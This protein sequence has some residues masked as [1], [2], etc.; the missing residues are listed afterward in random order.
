M[1]VFFYLLIAFG[2]LIGIL[3][4]LSWNENAAEIVICVLLVIFWPILI[5]IKISEKK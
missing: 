3:A 4:Q 1:F 5:G 2:T